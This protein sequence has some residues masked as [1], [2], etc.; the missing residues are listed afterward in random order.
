M[1]TKKKWTAVGAASVLGLGLIGGGAVATASAMTVNSTL[2]L[3]TGLQ[4]VSN[5]QIATDVP[6][7]VGSPVS[8]ASVSDASAQ[9]ADS[10]LSP[11]SVPTAESAPS[12]VSPASPIS[13]VSVPS[14][15]SAASDDSS[16]SS[17]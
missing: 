16:G 14:A 8:V 10:A 17:D 11:V 2:D 6:R 5:E 9:T 7:F 3:V 13:P 15:P 12:V 1:D 4:P